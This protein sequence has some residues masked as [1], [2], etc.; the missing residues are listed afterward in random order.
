MIHWARDLLQKHSHIYRL[1][2]YNNLT[3][4][5]GDGRWI[6]VSCN[7][8][9]PFE[10]GN[11]NLL[12]PWSQKNYQHNTPAGSLPNMHFQVLGLSRSHN[13]KTILWI[14]FNG[15]RSDSNTTLELHVEHTVIFMTTICLNVNLP[16]PP[17]ICNIY[18]K[19]MISFWLLYS[20]SVIISKC[21]WGSASLVLKHEQLRFH[22]CCAIFTAELPQL[23][24]LTAAFSTTVFLRIHVAHVP[25][26][27]WSQWGAFEHS[28]QHVKS[29]GSFHLWP[30]FSKGQRPRT[31]VFL[32][33]LCKSASGCGI[34]FS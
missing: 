1:Y 2:P 11:T 12:D 26:V 10:G 16:T 17:R 14:A 9:L 23:M 21:S 18:V 32:I 30:D 13:P 4:L 33:N 3:I 22:K 19:Q 27:L 25:R 20:C 5:V 28:F 31:S 6:G 24:P 15:F 8:I 29:I 7:I 34:S